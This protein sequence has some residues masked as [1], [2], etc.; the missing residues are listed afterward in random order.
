MPM[1]G[2]LAPPALRRRWRGDENNAAWPEIFHP[3]DSVEPG[4]IMFSAAG[5]SMTVLA[6][7]SFPAGAGEIAVAIAQIC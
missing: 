6:M 2:E 1:R 5:L 7:L 3:I 4:V